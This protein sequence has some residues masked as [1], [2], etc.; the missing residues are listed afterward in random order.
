MKVGVPK[1]TLEHE[2]RVALV[3]DVVKK[4]VDRG[5]EV[6]FE[7]GAGERA[8]F[9]DDSYRDAGANVV[10]SPGE[11]LGAADVVQLARSPE[12]SLA[13]GLAHGATVVPRLESKTSSRWGLGDRMKARNWSRGSVFRM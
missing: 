12:L 6:V 11:V 8:S 2:S 10:G 5:F 9:T 7:A 4:L 3:P 13:G 1:E